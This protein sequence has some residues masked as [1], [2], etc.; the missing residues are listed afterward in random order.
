MKNYPWHIAVV[1][2][3][4]LVF[5]LSATLICA[6]NKSAGNTITK[7][8]LAVVDFAALGPG[9]DKDLGKAVAEL[10]RSCFVDTGKYTVIDKNTMDKTILEKRITPTEQTGIE[11]GKL[12]N[13]DFVVDGSILKIGLSYI[14]TGKLANVKTGEVLRGK[15]I[16]GKSDDQLPDMAKQ[17]VGQLIDSPAAYSATTTVSIISTVSITTTIIELNK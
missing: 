13:A 11:L 4:I 2:L 9:I 15:N 10:M 8:K 7:S 17:L 14:M 1:V 6:E 12:Y 16:A 3:T 5:V